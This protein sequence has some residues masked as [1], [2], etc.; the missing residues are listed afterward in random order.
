MGRAWLVKL[1]QLGK[2]DSEKEAEE[3]EESDDAFEEDDIINILMCLIMR[4]YMTR[5]EISLQ[6]KI[7]SSWGL[8]GLQSRLP[9]FADC[10][11]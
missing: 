11:W 10:R 8:F 9:F 7:L 1:L 6:K 5:T 4:F 2:M 3:E